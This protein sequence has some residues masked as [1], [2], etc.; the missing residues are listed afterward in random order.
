MMPERALLVMTSHDRLGDTGRTTGAYM[1]EIV[2]AWQV[3][4]GAGYQV[5]LASVR[6]GRP[7]LEAVR[8][9][10]ARHSAFLDDPEMKVRLASTL[11]VG[12]AA[13]KDYAVVFLAGGHGAAWDFPY[14]EDLAVFIR[15]MYESDGVVAAVCHGPAALVNATRS[16]GT[17]LVA[18]LRLTAFTNDEERAVGMTAIVPFLLAD[19]LAER[20]AAYVGG[21]SF[22]PLVVTDGNLVTG[23]N[24]ASAT[25]V[26]RRALTLT[27]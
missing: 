16:D 8:P 2:D 17:P 20:G 14:D 21:P 13:A 1:S 15:D 10:D 4:A 11:R 7:P 26:A 12:D 19:R 18:G 3:F 27:R 9:D 6:G 22:I 5:D 23:Q 24:P 25:E